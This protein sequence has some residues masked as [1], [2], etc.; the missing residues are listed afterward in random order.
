MF[1]VDNR[2]KVNY[3]WR[4][5]QKYS[6]S[7]G[8]ICS[9]SGKR[10][11]VTS[12]A[13]AQEPHTRHHFSHQRT[14]AG[15]PGICSDRDSNRKNCSAYSSHFSAISLIA[16]SRLSRSDVWK[17]ASVT[18]SSANSVS[19]KAARQTRTVLLLAELTTAG[20]FLAVMTII[21]FR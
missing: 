20:A 1:I 11:S 14:S 15:R 6:R 5:G 21:I 2:P 9:K 16:R 17:Y 10:E 12:P 13:R 19:M 4:F 3:R 18:S 8:N 7:L